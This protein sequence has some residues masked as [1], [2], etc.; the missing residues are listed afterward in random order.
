MAQV[1]IE[2]QRLAALDKANATRVLRARQKQALGNGGGRKLAAELL[3]EVPPFWET[4][5]VA[6]LLMSVRG[7]GKVKANRICQSIGLSPTKK[8]GQLSASTRGRLI[9]EI[10]R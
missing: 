8:L 5:T 7:I 9:Q 3:T 6:Q 4:A 1:A 2:A 10:A